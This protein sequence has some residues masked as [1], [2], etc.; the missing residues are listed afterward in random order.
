M[1]MKNMTTNTLQQ[2][3]QHKGEASL[4][5][6]VQVALDSNAEYSEAEE[7]PSSGLIEQW[8]RAAYQAANALNK[9]P[10]AQ[11]TVRIV[12]P[13]EITDL[14]HSYRHKNAPTNVLAFEL[15]LSDVDDLPITLLGDVVICHTVVAQE[16]RQQHKTL[17][18]HYAHM[19]THG[20]LHLCGFDHIN[21][22]DAN[23]M[24]ALETAILAQHGIANPYYLKSNK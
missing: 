16:A 18:H 2:P 15:G 5:V 21:E 4:Q 10:T 14:N 17:K 1:P 19:V 6:D 3:L 23:T 13:V 20:V 11:L 8:A 12:E 24:E 9:P 7:P 22:Q